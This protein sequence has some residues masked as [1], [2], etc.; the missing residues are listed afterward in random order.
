[1]TG[2]HAMVVMF[3]LDSQAFHAVDPTLSSKSIRAENIAQYL[4]RGTIC[5]R[6]TSPRPFIPEII[7]NAMKA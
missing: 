7:T 4:E 3:I 5:S 1:M 6:D 2:I